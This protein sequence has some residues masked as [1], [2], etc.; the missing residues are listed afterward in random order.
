MW[1]SGRAFQVQG[2]LG[3][4]MG[5]QVDEESLRCFM[6]IVVE[7]YFLETLSELIGCCK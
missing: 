5:R 1:I 3:L 6:I 7:R 4:T 2:I